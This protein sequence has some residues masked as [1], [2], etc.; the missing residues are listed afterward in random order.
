MWYLSCLLVSVVRRPGSREPSGPADG[1][2]AVLKA[3]KRAEFP[4]RKITLSAA[5]HTATLT[6]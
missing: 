1:T 6:R 5:W 2:Y 3:S 4:D